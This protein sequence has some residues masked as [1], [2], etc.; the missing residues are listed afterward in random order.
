MFDDSRLQCPAP[1][2]NARMRRGR[3]NTVLLGVWLFGAAGCSLALTPELA[4]T[5]DGT[6]GRT[7]GEGYECESGVCRSGRCTTECA[8]EQA[9]P[10]NSECGDDGFC[11][12]LSPPPL[13]DLRIGML[14]VGPVGDHGWTKAHD[15]GR[16][17]FLERIPGT[18]AMFAPSVSTVDA[19]ARIDEFVARGDNVIIATSHDFLVPVQAAALRYPNVNFLL[20]SGFSSGP[21]LGSYFG[22]MYQVMYQAGHLAGR[23][24]ETEIIGVVGPVVIPETVRHINAFTRGVKAANPRARV[25]VRW[26]HAW[27]DPDN[28]I[29]ATN[30]LIDAGADIVFGNTDTTIPIETVDARSTSETPV[31]SIGYDNPDSCSF[32]EE[33]CLTSAYWNWGPLTTRLL[34]Q[35]KEGTWRPDEMIWEQMRADPSESSAYLAPIN[36]DLVSSRDRIAVE[37]MVNEL[38]ADTDRAR[39]LPFL[40]PV[41]DNRGGTRVPEGQMPT[42]RDL[43]NM[44]WFV[45]GVY[46]IDGSAAMVPSQCVG[47]R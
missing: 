42:D 5:G 27:F 19:P 39:Y 41:R 4:D 17:Y 47:D 34:R 3:R 44:C 29:A 20:C 22:R 14:Y 8:G 15:D 35:M 1:P 37:E 12:P 31:Y 24:T 46:D 2:G 11:R 43:L 13:D 45:D 38:S 25:M 23:V 7:C 30:D 32:A 26:V 21:N 28:E 36:R 40:G 16:A 9:C 33:T 6:F 18:T 10:S